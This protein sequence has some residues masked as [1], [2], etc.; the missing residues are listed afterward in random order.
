MPGMRFFTAPSMTDQPSGTSISCSLP[1]CS[2]YLI[3]GMAA[4]WMTLA[5]RYVFHEDGGV[6]KALGCDLHALADQFASNEV[7]RGGIHGFHRGNS[8][9]TQMKGSKFAAL[10]LSPDHDRIV[11]TCEA[12]DLQFEV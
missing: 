12:G 7:L 9:F 1:L 10:G 4:P 8:P 2:M 11:R 5:S 3:F 6:R